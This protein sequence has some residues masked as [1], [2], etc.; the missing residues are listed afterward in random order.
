MK[1][2]TESKVAKFAK[3]VTI[4]L[5]HIMQL[6]IAT[7]VIEFVGSM[8]GAIAAALFVASLVIMFTIY[9]RFKF[10]RSV[11]IGWFGTDNQI[12]KGKLK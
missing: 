5:I 11:Y 1:K 10:V 4:E 7:I 2:K 9:Y 8:F 3:I 6:M 12:I